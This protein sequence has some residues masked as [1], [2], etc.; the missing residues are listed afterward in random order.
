MK[1]LRKVAMGWM[2][3]WLPVSGIM[4]STMPFCAQG[5]GGVL[6]AAMTREG[7]EVMRCHES[8][9][10]QEDTGA[11]LAVEHC[12]LCHIAGAMA[13]PTLP[14][15]ANPAPGLAPFDAAV[16]DFRSFIPDPLSRP[17]RPSP[18]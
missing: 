5:L 4:A 2:F 7:A 6:Y 14:V 17:P 16:S 3:A 18:V 13:P 15:V 10:A 1:R 12:D 9:A 11:P 8:G